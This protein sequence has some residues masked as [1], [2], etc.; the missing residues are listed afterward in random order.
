MKWPIKL[1]LLAL[2]IPFLY[3]FCEKETDGFRI[4]RLSTSC[5]FTMIADIPNEVNAALNQ[6]FHYLASGGQSWVF[7]SEDE[8]YVLK[9]FKAHLR[10]KKGKLERDFKS[11][12][13]AYDNLKEECG[14]VYLHLNETTTLKTVQVVD[15]LNIVHPIDLDKT[16]FLL[17]KKGV[18]LYE[19]LQ[20]LM[21]EK[22]LT[23]AK[24]ALSSLCHLIIKRSE[25]GIFDEDARIHC[26]LGFVGNQPILLDTGRLKW[27]EKRKN[28][29]IYRKD[30]KKITLK[31]KIWLEQHYP[32]LA[33]HLEKEVAS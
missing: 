10:S 32:E 23:G 25:K 5:H 12:Q 24:E 13:L 11:C 16:D 18:L 21:E 19:H 15:K 2:P 6:K 33:F 27:D 14:L 3:K 22:D 20:K 31:L 4:S 1:F 29:E 28:P 9:F 8:K 17:Q 7:V 26:N 30:L